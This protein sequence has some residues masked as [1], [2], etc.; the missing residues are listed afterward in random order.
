M[1]FKIFF[2]ISGRVWLNRVEV[3]PVTLA[4]YDREG[5]IAELVSFLAP[6][7]QSL[8]DKFAL[9]QQCVGLPAD[10]KVIK[11]AKAVGA[12]NLTELTNELK[13]ELNQWLGQDGWIDEYGAADQRVGL[14]LERFRQQ[15]KARDEVQIIVQ[16][17]DQLLRRLPWQEWD[18]L[19]GY[20][21]RGVEVAIG[22]T[23]FQRVRQQQ[24]PQIRATARI[25][26][27]FG[28]QNLGFEAEQGFIENLRRYGAEPVI[29]KQPK[30]LEL[31]ASL[32]D[33]QGWHI[34]FFA[35]HSESDR[36]KRVGW[37][38]INSIDGEEGII[39]I[40]ELQDFQFL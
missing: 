1:A 31:E 10:R 32:K 12:F 20:T 9:W 24:A 19:A 39:A 11:E 30:R 6:M 18:T 17:E 8:E 40:A 7:P 33:P 38:Q 35:G 13:V 14:M 25:L 2:K 27:V 4:F 37:F 5:Q 34:F 15:I 3:L 22:A 29:L 26:V 28:D 16:T 23:N 21:S 36:S